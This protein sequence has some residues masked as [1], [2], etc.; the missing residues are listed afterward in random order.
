MAERNNHNLAVLSARADPTSRQQGKAA[1]VDLDSTIDRLRTLYPEMTPRELLNFF[2]RL[3]A[4][5]DESG[6]LHPPGKRPAMVRN[7]RN[8]FQRTELTEAELRTLHG[9]VSALWRG[10]HG[11]G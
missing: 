7:I 3:E 6:F 11:E 4:R 2:G 5:L 8:L 10:K 1:T 9:I